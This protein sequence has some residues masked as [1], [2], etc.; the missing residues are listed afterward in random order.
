MMSGGWVINAEGISFSTKRAMQ[1]LKTV[2]TL[3]KDKWIEL[4]RHFKV[5][6][7][8]TS[9]EIAFVGARYCDFLDKDLMREW[10]AMYTLNRSAEKAKGEI[11]KQA[12]LIN[13]GLQDVI[14]D[15]ERTL[16]ELQ[17]LLFTLENPRER[18]T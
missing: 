17:N 7:D 14:E 8:F 3:N 9:A 10:L 12:N 6:S 13:Q 11:L 5:T 2:S 15:P 4:A 1:E 16:E 18:G